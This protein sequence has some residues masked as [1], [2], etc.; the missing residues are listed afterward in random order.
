MISIKKFENIFGISQ[1]KGADDL[2]KINVIY[3]P[4]G[5]AKTSIADALKHISDKEIGKIKDVYG[6][7][8]E[9]CFDI[10]VD[11]KSCT[12]KNLID[13]KVIKYSG[14]EFIFI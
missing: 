1:L 6:V 11:G 2:S 12:E 13:F 10:N 8:S 14:D 4:N 5:T 9:P 3:A 7:T